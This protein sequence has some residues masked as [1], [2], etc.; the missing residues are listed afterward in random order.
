MPRSL[1]L[2]G[3]ALCRLHCRRNSIS[4]DQASSGASCTPK[5]RSLFCRASPLEESFP[6]LCPSLFF[7]VGFRGSQP[8]RSDTMSKRKMRKQTGRA[9][10]NTIGSRERD[11]RRHRETGKENVQ[12]ANQKYNMR[13]TFAF[14]QVLL[15]G[16]TRVRRLH[17]R[18]IKSRLRKLPWNIQGG[19]FLVDCSTQPFDQSILIRSIARR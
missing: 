7:D 1:H 13:T 6:L 18:L 17:Y 9:Q 10:P 8:S 11:S 4:R 3:R 2:S 15:A 16:L 19:V 12:G 5:M 14:I